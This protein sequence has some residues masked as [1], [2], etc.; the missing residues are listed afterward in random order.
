MEISI[1][2]PTYN[3]K[4]VLRE[5][6]QL[7]NNQSASR[8]DFE[9]LLIDDGST[10]G[11]EELVGTVEKNYNFTYIRQD[12]QG[13]AVARNNGVNQAKGRIILFFDDDVLPHPELIKEHLILQ[14]NRNNLIVRGPVINIPEMKIPQDRP[15]GFWDMNKNFF[16][17]SNVSAAKEHIIKAGSFD[18]SFLWW[19]D[20][21]L[22]FRLRMM[23]LRW[24]FSFKAIVFHYKPFQPDELAYIKKWAIKKAVYAVK[25]YRKHPHW[26]IKLGTGI[27]FLSFLNLK[28]FNPPFLIKF[29]EQIFNSSESRFYYRSFLTSQ[30]G[31]YYYLNTIKEE[32]KKTG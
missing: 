32:L 12:N 26:R 2:I 19:E 13:Q 8:D 21:E 11:T 5:C 7:I 22:G 15:V 23:G 24:T 20:C 16:C 27:H 28:I 18:P 29:Y 14:N 30:I 25:L 9:I 3:R 17:T 4:D 1:V 31:N 10:D 6:L